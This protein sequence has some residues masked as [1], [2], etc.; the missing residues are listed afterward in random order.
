V[1]GAVR[2]P[3]PGASARDPGDASA[4]ELAAEAE[5]R[6]QKPQRICVHLWRGAERSTVEDVWV[7]VQHADGVPALH[8]TG[9]G[10]RTR[11]ATLSAGSS[12]W[13]TRSVAATPAARSQPQ[14]RSCI[15][16]CRRA[17]QW[18]A[19]PATGTQDVCSRNRW[20]SQRLWSRTLLSAKNVGRSTQPKSWGHNRIRR[21]PMPRS[22]MLPIGIRMLPCTLLWLADLHPVAV[23]IY[24]FCVRAALNISCFFAPVSS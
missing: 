23:A 18:R 12:A 6:S 14:V 22:L 9:S 24:G 16:A 1:T 10:R 15:C 13:Q 8:A 2:P 19:P 5:A 20:G 17:M 7:S 4:V 11:R 21:N 3:S